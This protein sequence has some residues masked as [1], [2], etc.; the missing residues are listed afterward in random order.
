MKHL[1]SLLK[2]CDICINVLSTITLDAFIFDKPVINP[3][4]GNE[5]NGMFNDQKF[6][7][8]AHLANLVD[9]KSSDIVKTT[10]EFL[11]A[12]NNI[13]Q[14]NDDKSIFRAKFLELQISASLEGTSKRIAQSLAQLNG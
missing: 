10:E 13:L 1:K 12:L 11:A 8:Y 6:L 3:V 5:A 4:F 14:G 2:Y 7:N 9:S